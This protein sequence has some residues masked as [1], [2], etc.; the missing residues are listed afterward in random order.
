MSCG[1][2]IADGFSMA[3]SN[4]LATRAERQQRER[5]RHQEERHIALVPD[6]E[7]EEVR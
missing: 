2:L 4:L 1:Q 6:G 3:L 7:R 5:A